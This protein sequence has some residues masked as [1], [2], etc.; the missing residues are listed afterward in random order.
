MG[1]RPTGDGRNILFNLFSFSLLL[2]TSG[3]EP[4][5]QIYKIRVIPF[6]YAGLKNIHNLTVIRVFNELFSYSFGF[7]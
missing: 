5:T 4:K 7:F 6:N 2:P 1:K 3:I